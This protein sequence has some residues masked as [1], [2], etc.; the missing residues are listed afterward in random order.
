MNTAT[1]LL[2]DLRILE[3]PNPWYYW[4]S[5]ILVAL[6][7]GSLVFYWLKARQ[8]RRSLTPTAAAVH[9][10]ED[11]LAALEKARALIA[12]GNSKAY[13][14]EVSSVVR[15]YIENRFAILAPR[16]STEEFLDE[17]RRSPKLEPHYQALLAEFLKGCDFL[18]F[19]RG[20]AEIPELQSLH[21]SAV[22]FVSE[23]KLPQAGSVVTAS[24]QETAR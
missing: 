5:L 7:L 19:A 24:T 3:A 8:R 2:D 13:A 4:P 20:V 14:V 10:H 16:Q 18:K 21:A 9:A 17:A 23:T 11:A 12:P 22:R 15:R 1:N 6:V